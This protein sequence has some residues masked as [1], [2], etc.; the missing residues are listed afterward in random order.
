MI[1]QKGSVRIDLLGGTL[2]LEPINL[3]IPN[4]VTINAALD[5]KA[6]VKIEDTQNQDGVE[7]ISQDYQLAKT[8]SKQQLESKQLNSDQ[9]GALYF[10]AV[11][12]AEL[13]LYSGVK[14]TLSSDAPAGSG[15][16]GS[17]TI[18]VTLVEALLQHQGRS[19][20]KQEIVSLVRGVEG[21]ILDCGPAGHQDYYPALYGGVLALNPTPGE[22]QVEQLY[23]P[24]LKKVLE[25]SLTLVYSGASRLSGINN[26][27]VYKSFFDHDFNVRQGLGKIADLAHQAKIAIKS[28]Q[29]NQ[30]I[31][32]IAQEGE[33]RKELFPNILTPQMKELHQKISLTYPSCG[34]KVC[35]A[36]GGGC[37]L[38]THPPKEAFAIR[39]IIQQDKMEQL[40]LT[41]GP[42]IS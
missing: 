21:K 16:G 30:L 33:V 36:G 27:E 8:I 3:I 23:T 39:E 41:I 35:G 17:S 10:L 11:L 7:I 29:F 15:L 24:Q 34:I 2:D 13:K 1:I 25:S 42:P 31:N 12:I 4:V 22:L 28:E 14:I 5:L 37:F 18:G 20:S 40:D 6:V 9:L 26:W 38:L 32:L 19:F